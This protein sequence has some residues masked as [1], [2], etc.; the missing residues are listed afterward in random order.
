MSSGDVAFVGSVPEV[1]DRYMGPMIFEPYAVDIAGRVPPDASK[2]LEIA[3]G[4]GISTRAIRNALSAPA[5]L[6]ATDLNQE[7]INRARSKFTA[8]ENVELR[9]ADATSLPFPDASFD[10]IVC[11]FGMMFFPDKDAALQE[12]RRVLRPGGMFLFSVWDRLEKNEISLAVHEAFQ[13]FYPDDPPRFYCVPF[14]LHDTWL[15]HS[16]LEA[17]AFTDIHWSTVQKTSVSPSAQNAAAGLVEGT[18]V[19]GQ[20]A[21]RGAERLPDLLREVAEE[22]RR[23]FGDHPVTTKMQALVWSACSPTEGAG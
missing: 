16:M 14:G 2:V 17:H 8:I 11:Q 18:P 20:I 21:E 1:Y 6:I 5:R 7:M 19:I 9:Q 13:S 4:T 23:R 12:V 10:T 22:I 3:C 15:I